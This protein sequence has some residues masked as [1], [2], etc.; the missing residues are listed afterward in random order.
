MRNNELN[1]LEISAECLDSLRRAYSNVNEKAVEDCTKSELAIAYAAGELQ[2]D[3]TQKFRNH[4]H[5]CNYCL[6]LRLDFKV[7]ESDSAVNSKCIPKVLPGLAG[8][9]EVNETIP[10]SNSGIPLILEIVFKYCSFLLSPK[11]IAVAV[12]AC[13]AFIMINFGLNDPEIVEKLGQSNKSI[14]P[15]GNSQTQAP[16]T[17]P[18]FSK[19]R[20]AQKEQ[21]KQQKPGSNK[22]TNA[23]NSTG[24]LDPFEDPFKKR[25]HGLAKK[26]MKRAIRSPLENIDLS[27][28]KLVG[29]VISESG[30]KALL[31]DATGKGYTIKNGTYIGKKGGKVIEITKDKVLIEEEFENELGKINIKKT[32][33]K[34][35][36]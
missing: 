31:E 19:N 20:I 28:L 34:L 29:I 24:K 22:K 17:K 12:T 18:D 6:N 35:Q 11:F 23:Y 26:R 7:A 5:T 27:Q 30:N 33:L 8:V 2:P 14:T 13:L 36:K 16:E 10:G 21:I 32:E 25:T 15:T 3:E 9:I 1:N 4:L